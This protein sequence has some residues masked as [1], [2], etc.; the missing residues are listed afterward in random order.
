[1]LAKIV[2]FSVFCAKN[3]KKSRNLQQISAISRNREISDE[4]Y[5][6]WIE[7]IKEA[8]AKMPKET[9]LNLPTAKEEFDQML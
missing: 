7:I 9:D 2:I 8:S 3:L 6:K 4:F 1:M 5:G